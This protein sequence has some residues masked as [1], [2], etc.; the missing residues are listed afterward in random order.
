M[1]IM[2]IRPANKDIHRTCMEMRSFSDDDSV[3]LSK[4]VNWKTNNHTGECINVTF[5][6]LTEMY[7][8]GKENYEDSKL[9]IK[10]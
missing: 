3:A 8:K 4:F 5:A 7:E 10:I 9:C 1:I 2:Y 6:N